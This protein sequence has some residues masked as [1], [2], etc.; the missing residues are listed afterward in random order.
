MSR[1]TISYEIEQRDAVLTQIA[2]NEKILV[3]DN[4]TD[5]DANGRPTNCFVI[6]EAAPPVEQNEYQTYY[7]GMTEVLEG[8]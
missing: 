8:E 1:E 7:E 2:A 4:I 5:L 3:H 6:V